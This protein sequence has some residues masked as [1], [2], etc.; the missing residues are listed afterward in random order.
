MNTP[1]WEKFQSI[2]SYSCIFFWLSCLSNVVL[3]FGW[4]LRTIW[5]KQS[6][7]NINLMKH[8]T[9]RYALGVDASG[10]QRFFFFSSQSVVN[11]GIP[12]PFS[13]VD[14]KGERQREKESEKFKGKAKVK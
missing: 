1:F 13:I 10:S 5:R 2:C 8:I 7:V 12:F 4:L 9:G 14:G 11:L 3:V 6:D